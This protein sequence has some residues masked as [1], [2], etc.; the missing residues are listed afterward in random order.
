MN[1]LFEKSN[2][3]LEAFDFSALKFSNFKEGF[4]RAFQEA[5]KNLELIKKNSDKPSFENTILTLEQSSE[6]LD[7]VSS[8]FF[9]LLSTEGG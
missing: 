3:T 2:F 1:I 4:E 8:I 6:L 9:N 5:R 7:H